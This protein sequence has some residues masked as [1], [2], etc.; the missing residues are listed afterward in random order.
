M[1]GGKEKCFLS[2]HPSFW[3][4]GIANYLGINE[5]INLSVCLFALHTVMLAHPY[6]FH[7]DRHKQTHTSADNN[8]YE[9][10][11]LIY[12]VMCMFIQQSQKVLQGL[13]IH[14]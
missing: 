3:D 8:I 12:K 11:D 5:T 1:G 6:F 10:G 2:N 7:T 13:I 9:D 14:T 4:I